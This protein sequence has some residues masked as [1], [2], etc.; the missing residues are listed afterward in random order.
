MFGGLPLQFRQQLGVSYC[1]SNDEYYSDTI[2]T[3]LLIYQRGTKRHRVRTPDARKVG[4]VVQSLMSTNIP[5]I[6]VRRAATCCTFLR[7]VR[8]RLSFLVRVLLMG[9]LS[10]RSWTACTIRELARIWCQ[11]FT[12]L[13]PNGYKGGDADDHDDGDDDEDDGDDSANN[14]CFG[15]KTR[16]RH[17]RHSIS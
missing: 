12:L 2:Q 9:P 17:T 5:A 1:M 16:R 11:A 8:S 13:N 6:D 3:P 15:F 4:N 10:V 7:A 14:D